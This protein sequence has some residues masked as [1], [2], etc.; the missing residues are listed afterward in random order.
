MHTI[1]LNDSTGRESL[2]SLY[3]VHTTT[4]LLAHM[5]DFNYKHAAGETIK[6]VYKLPSLARAFRYLHAAA[7]FPTEATCIKITRNGYYLTWPLLTIHNVNRNF[8][9]SEETKKGHMW[10][11]CHGVRSTKAKSP[12]PG[13]ESPPA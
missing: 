3:T 13:T 7:V 4:S 6:S 9:G 11:Q 5:E 2:N 1:L 10:N 12:H 8:P